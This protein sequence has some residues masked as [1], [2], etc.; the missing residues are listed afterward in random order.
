MKKKSNKIPTRKNLE[1]RIKGIYQGKRDFM[2]TKVLWIIAIIIRYFGDADLHMCHIHTCWSVT[3]H[4]NNHYNVPKDCIYQ[5]TTSNR[6]LE[7]PPP[8]YSRS[9]PRVKATPKMMLHIERLT[10]RTNYDSRNVKTLLPPNSPI[11]VWETYLIIPRNTTADIYQFGVCRTL[12]LFLTLVW[13][14][15]FWR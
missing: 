2:K 5:E 3:N 8:S 7:P 14:V 13:R 12:C 11:C 10:R 1:M 4:L 15:A 6:L 9:L